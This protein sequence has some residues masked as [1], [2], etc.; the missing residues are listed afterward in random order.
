VI[1]MTTNNINAVN[2]LS[3]FK[4][5]RNRLILDDVSLRVEAGEFA[6]IY[7]V[8]G[9]GKS[10]L[11]RVISGLVLPDSGTVHVFGNQVGR[12]TEFP[13]NLG[14]MID[15][16]GFL[17]DRSGLYNLQLLA[18]IRNIIPP[19]RIIE[20]LELVGLNSGDKRPVKTYSTGMR[21]RLGIAQAIMEYP[22][23]LILDE[24]T[25]ALDADGAQQIENVLK[26]MQKQGVTIIIVSHKPSELDSLCDSIYKM[27]DGRLFPFG[28]DIKTARG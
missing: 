28:E 19:Q 2:V 14:A 7:G 21:Q 23:L 9:S 3:V 25:S 24:P 11:L 12:D 5:I 4:T 26:E 13:S 15:G 22:K 17:L 1:L 27:H 18:S 6:G 8:N 20:A 10:M 16:P